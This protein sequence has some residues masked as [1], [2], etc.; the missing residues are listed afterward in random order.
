[1]YNYTPSDPDAWED[2]VH[3]AR[4]QRRQH[5]LAMSLPPGHPDEPEM[6]DEEDGD[7]SV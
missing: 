2:E 1:M 5:R 7:G 6:P 4:W 3:A